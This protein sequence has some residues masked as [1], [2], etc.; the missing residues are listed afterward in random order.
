MKIIYGL[1]SLILVTPAYA[2]Y[3]EIWEGWNIVAIT[4]KDSVLQF[5][6]EEIVNEGKYKK[7]WIREVFFNSKSKISTMT[8]MKI[9]CTAKNLR[10]INDI[11][12]DKNG[13]LIAQRELS[14]Q[15]VLEVPPGSIGAITVK[16]ICTG[17]SSFYDSIK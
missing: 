3:Y 12:Y 13:N 5:N 16:T 17:K 9:D 11:T 1:I 10:L 8:L 14:S 6:P 4:D 7:A 15:K 2:E